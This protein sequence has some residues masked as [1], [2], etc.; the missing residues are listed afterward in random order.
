MSDP[1]RTAAIPTV[2]GLTIA[3]MAKGVTGAD[4]VKPWP[5]AN[6]ELRDL[7]ELLRTHGGELQNTSHRGKGN[8]RTENYRI[9]HQ[10]ASEGGTCANTQAQKGG[11][12]S[13]TAGKDEKTSFTEVHV[14]WAA[15]NVSTINEAL[16]IA[17]AHSYNTRFA[18]KITVAGGTARAAPAPQRR[19]HCGSCD[20]VLG[21]SI[22]FGSQRCP[23]C[24]A[25][26][27][28]NFS[29]RSG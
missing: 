9:D 8:V 21:T 28:M 7:F 16:R 29:Y 4:K 15:F 6:A 10:G 2:A 13:Y 23:A 1:A 18:V 5:P 3:V 22:P 11:F 17:H 25:E 12:K 26:V 19:A 24:G 14:A 27:G 20:T